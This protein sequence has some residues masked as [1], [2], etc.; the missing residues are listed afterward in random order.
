M[1]A[2]KF[3]LLVLILKIIRERLKLK[4]YLAV[5]SFTAGVTLAPSAT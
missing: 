4:K 1:K 2:N 3:S 5:N